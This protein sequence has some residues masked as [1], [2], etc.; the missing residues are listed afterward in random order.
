MK[1]FTVFITG[2]GAPG[3]RGVMKCYRIGAREEKRRIRLITCDMNPQ[4]YGFHLADASYVV[5]PGN[6]TN[7]VNKMLEICRKERPDLVVSGVDNELLPLAKAKPEFEKIGAKVVLSDPKAIEIAVDKG[8]TYEFFRGYKFI[9]KNIIIRNSREFRK[10]AGSLGY[11]KSPVCFK[12]AYSYGMRGFRIVRPDMDTSDIFFKEKP[13][14]VFMSLPEA[15]E[16]FEKYEEKGALPIMLVMEYL[17]GREYTVDMLLRDKEPLVTIPRERV[18][19]RQGIS[20]T[21]RIEKNLEIMDIAERIARKLGL[22]YNANLQLK[23]SSEGVPK[24][25]EVQPRLAGT[26]IAC[27]GA[28]ANLPY[29]ALKIALGEKFSLPKVR[30]GTVAKRFWEEVYTDGKD[31]WFYGIKDDY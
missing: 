18:A 19:T 13:A 4:A 27:A 9:P 2:A 31:S 28:G 26:T 25:I 23:Y 8:K 1:P 17:E 5:P 24:L 14:S 7:Y 3:T 15:V 12:P 20:T 16:I 29:L 10:A 30:W 21:A 11:P 22:N 6:D